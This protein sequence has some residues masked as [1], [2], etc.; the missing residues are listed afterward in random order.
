[1]DFK[2]ILIVTHSNAV[3]STSLVIVTTPMYR[4]TN[5]VNGINAMIFF[6][7][8]TITECVT[9]TSQL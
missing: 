4:V 6:Y 5:G 9:D 2:P 8:K 7:S 1:M 3:V